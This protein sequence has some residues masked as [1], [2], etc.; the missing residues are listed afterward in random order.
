LP[1]RHVF[2]AYEQIAE[3]RER[4]LRLVTDASGVR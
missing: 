2:A 3:L 1:G 4:G